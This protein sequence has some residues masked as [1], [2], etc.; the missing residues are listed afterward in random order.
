MQSHVNETMRRR[1]PG[2]LP[3]AVRRRHR[4]TGFGMI[5]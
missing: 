5:A 1:G 2:K 4:N 3:G